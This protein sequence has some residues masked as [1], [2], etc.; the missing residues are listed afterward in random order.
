[1]EYL[2]INDVL[3]IHELVNKAQG[4]DSQVRDYNMLDSAVQSPFAGFGGF[5]KY[6]SIEE[7][8]A[9]LGY[10][11]NRNHAFIDGNKRTGL[12]ALITSLS[13]NGI[14]L[15]FTDDELYKF[16]IGMAEGSLNYEDILDW[17]NKHK[18]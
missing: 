11:L 10:A 16:G 15:K 8:A 3:L 12:I 1:M 6:P 4:S 13:I 5:E 18:V 7:K 9:R 17:I 14:S 2:N